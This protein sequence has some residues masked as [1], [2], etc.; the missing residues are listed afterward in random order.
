MGADSPRRLPRVRSATLLKK[1][2]DLWGSRSRPRPRD[3]GPPVCS[4][5]SVRSLPAPP[6]YE[7]KSK[8]TQPLVNLNTRKCFSATQAENLVQGLLCLLIGLWPMLFGPC[9][10]MFMCAQAVGNF[11]AHVSIKQRGA[12]ALKSVIIII[13]LF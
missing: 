5:I 12:V 8:S 3:L 9:I 2:P 1:Q 7:G 6:T 10:G 13:Y 4:S 11:F